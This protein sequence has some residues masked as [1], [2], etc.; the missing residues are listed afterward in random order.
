MKTRLGKWVTILVA[1]FLGIALFVE[2]GGA[3]EADKFPSRPI[4]YIS[5]TTAGGPLD[6]QAR[7]ICKEAEKYLKQPVVVLN[8]PGGGGTIATATLAA[9]KPDGHTVGTVG[10]SAIYSA[11][12]LEKLVYQP[13]KD[14][15]PVMQFAMY[16]F[17][18]IVKADSQFKTFKDIVEYARQNPK[19][20]TFGTNGANTLQTVITMQL[21]KKEK[22]DFIPIPFKGTGEW[23]SALLG[24]H[25]QFSVGDFNYS[26]VDAGQVRVILLLREE[27]SPDFPGVPIL[28]DLGYNYI[29]PMAN[30]V[31]TQ[32]AVPDGVVRKLEDAFTKAMKEPGFIKG[33][34]ELHA[35]IVYR[36]E[37]ESIDFFRKTYEFYGKI[38]KEMD[39]K[40]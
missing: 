39:I 20:L 30:M 13:L 12:F 19:K 5:M 11:P 8:K 2:S 36:N 25:V 26:L 29:C 9:A 4:T 17:G 32:K 27:R 28:K 23:Q 21:A 34:K 35:D 3:D 7:L 6:L 31:F 16:N 18:I 10:H 38:I 33:M 37:K 14:L 22:V 24:G 1:S 40:R 15:R